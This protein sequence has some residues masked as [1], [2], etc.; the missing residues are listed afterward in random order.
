MKTLQLKQHG[1][2]RYSDVSPFPLGDLEIEIAGIPNIAAEFRFI[3]KCNDV[4]VAEET[5][6]VTKNR[7]TISQTILSAGRFSAQVQ[8]YNKG[9]LA[10]IFTCEELI[11]TEL[12]D[13]LTAEPVTEQLRR[14]VAA[15]SKDLSAER[16]ARLEAENKVKEALQYAH[17]IALGLLRFAYEDYCENVYLPGGTFEEFLKD[18][19]IDTKGFTP[20]EI[21]K[22][23]GE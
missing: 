10:K 15:L 8:Q 2:G 4:K 3:G 13:G 1:T 17:E 22:I 21:N 20:E 23:K 19:G 5:V 16:E 7:V 9:I 11:I 14:N 18:Y 6:N 12:G